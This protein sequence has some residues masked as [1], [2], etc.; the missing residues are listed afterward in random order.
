MQL[1]IDGRLSITYEWNERFYLN[2]FG[3]FGSFRYKYDEIKGRLNDWYIN[4][5]I[6]IRL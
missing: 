6:G 1:N 5:A 4:A 2:A 3:Q